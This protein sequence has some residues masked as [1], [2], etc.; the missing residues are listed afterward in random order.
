MPI[1]REYS[2]FS[3]LLAMLDRLHDLTIRLSRT[4]ELLID[5]QDE[6]HWRK[7]AG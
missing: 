7:E 1:W 4:N 5:G 3:S 2:R 6:R